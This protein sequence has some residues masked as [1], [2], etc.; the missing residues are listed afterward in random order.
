M[1][2]SEV[3]QALNEHIFVCKHSNKHTEKSYES[4]F[5]EAFYKKLVKFSS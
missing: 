2:N 5:I 3:T 1:F 4:P